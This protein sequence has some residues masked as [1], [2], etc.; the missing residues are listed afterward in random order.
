MPWI[1]LAASLWCAWFTYNALQS[2]PRDK[3]FSV[4][5]FAAGWLTS[6]LALH[7]IGWQLIATVAFGAA[8]AFEHWPGRLGL[9]ITLGSWAG[10][11]AA[12]LVVWRL[13]P[14]ERPNVLR[15]CAIAGCAVKASNRS[16][17]KN[18]LEWILIALAFIQK[19]PHALIL[20]SFQDD[21]QCSFTGLLGLF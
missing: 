19:P 13:A 11:L 18:A 5:S 12:L 4:V 8:G 15:A 16:T 7:H 3:R 21:T 2:S 17:A 14:K 6:E 20:N 10:L 9:L 1:Y